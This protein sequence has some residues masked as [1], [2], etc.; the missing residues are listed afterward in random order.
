[1]NGAWDAL[2][3]GG[4]AG[5]V[6]VA[7]GGTALDWRRYGTW[8]TPFAVLAVPVAAVTVLAFLLARSLGFVALDSRVALLWLGALSLY[9]L[10]GFAVL[11]PLRRSL[12]ARIAAQTAPHQDEEAYWLVIGLAWLALILMAVGLQLALAAAGGW[13]GLGTPAFRSIL[14]GGLFGHA[15]VFSLLLLVY[16]LGSRRLR[17]PLTLLTIAGIAT[18]ALLYGVKSWLIL[19][20]LG[21]IYYRINSGRLRVS[22]G[23]LL[24]VACLGMGMFFA[25][26]L[27]RFAADGTRSLLDIVT[28]QELLRHFGAYLFAG[29]LGF[30]EFLRQKPGAITLGEEMA[31]F[32]PFVNLFRF[33]FQGDLPMVQVI[34]PNYLIISPQFQKFSNVPTLAGTLWLYWGVGGML[35]YMAALSIV[36][37][38]CFALSHWLRNA[39]LLVL[40]SFWAAL[41]SASWFEMYFWHLTSIEIPALALAMMA[42]TAAWGRLG[43]WRR[44]EVR[45]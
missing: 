11:W 45:A 39:W 5:L 1:M 43:T 17:E 31:I 35:L 36:M 29:V 7:A 6:L 16:L 30:S 42:L 4:L 8:L 33:L 20:V 44:V 22:L 41:L 28:Y 26:Y 18:I 23:L 13:E 10:L 12:Q 34:N 24:V 25:V 3:L 15:S 14:G 40:W 32:A 21:G 27:V 9:W 2:G 38:L 19:P 37:H